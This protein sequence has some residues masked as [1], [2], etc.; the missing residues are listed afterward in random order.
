MSQ[1]N[2]RV[3][4]DYEVSIPR[5]AFD[6]GVDEYLKVCAQLAECYSSQKRHDLAAEKYEAVKR[7]ILGEV[8]FD[9]PI[10]LVNTLCSLANAQMQLNAFEGARENYAHALQVI[11][12]LG[13]SSVKFG[14]QQ[15]SK[16]LFNMG[17]I[18]SATDNVEAAVAF[19]E[20]CLGA[21]TSQ[22]EMLKCFEVLGHECVKAQFFNNAIDWFQKGM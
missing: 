4:F 1:S 13:S 17:V 18:E 14:T 2:S 9:K 11:E 16:I 22:K 7:R 20:A 12:K 5:E 3:P 21:S 10:L 6:F 8:V 15:V 19:Y